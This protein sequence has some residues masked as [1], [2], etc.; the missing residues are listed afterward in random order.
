MK[1]GWLWFC[2]NAP[3]AW[4]CPR[5][6]TNRIVL[7]SAVLTAVLAL[8]F[9]WQ[10]ALLPPVDAVQ[11]AAARTNLLWMH[12][13]KAL[14]AGLG[15]PVDTALDPAK[16]GLIG[17]EF[18]DLT[19]T[20]GS[21]AA[22]RTTL[23]PDFAALM[24]ALL[25]EAGTQSGDTVAVSLT[26]SFPALNLAVL[27][28]CL[29]LELR[30]LIISSVGASSY[31]AVI[32]GLTWADMERHLWDIGAIPFRSIGMSL[33]GIVDTEGGIDG[34]GIDL[35]LAA[36][37]RGGVPYLPEGERGRLESDIMRRMQLYTKNG[38][39]TAFINVGGAV[40]ALGWVA[41]A[42]LLDNGLLRR[43]P[44]TAS[45]QRGIIF[46]MHEAGI[47]VI[48][49]LHIERL[50][51]QYGLPLAPAQLPEPGTSL[52]AGRGTRLSGL[53]ALLTV[54]AGLAWFG[55]TSPHHNNTRRHKRVAHSER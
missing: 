35:G 23:N 8:A 40:T 44:A 25:R 9:S 49:L 39:P 12:E 24:V 41:E 4:V 31:G 26:G 51:A 1:A 55:C 38:M 11:M 29:H 18:T 22:K 37:A 42:A 20:I 6:R 52:G 54:W 10:T 14:R 28:A 13:I 5:P 46:R 45:P 27:A 19:S 32:P 48:H 36:I 33:G 34:T 3:P 7:L 30:P 50:A 17:N 43:V 16:S 21:L 2:L 53:A 47:P 15:I